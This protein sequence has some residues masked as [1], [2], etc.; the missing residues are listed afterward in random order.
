MIAKREIRNYPKSA[1]VWVGKYRHS[2]NLLHWHYDCELLY[3]ESGKIDVF[4]RKQ[5]HTLTRGEALYVDR[6]QV[7]YMTAEDENTTLV[8]II[9]DYEIL[10]PYMGNV[11]LAEPVLKGD[12]NIPEVYRRMRDILLKKEPFYGAEATAEIMRLMSRIFR[13]ETVVPRE[14]EDETEHRFISLLEHA[15]D[16]FRFFTFADAVAYMGMSDSY[17]S[18]YFKGATGITFSQYLNYLRVEHAVEMLQ[19]EKDASMTEIADRCGFGTIR[20]FNRVFR[21]TTGYSPRELP[22]EY[23]MTEDFIYPSSASFDPTLHDCELLESAH[24]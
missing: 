24:G 23:R 19:T 14:A 15:A 11:G 2:H 18:R 9:F 8:V 5:L 12:Y 4:C 6:G 3:V 22:A 1:K 21:A 16:N 20:S 17:F 13:G 10:R 7:H